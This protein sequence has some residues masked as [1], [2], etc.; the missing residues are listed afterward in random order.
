MSDIFDIPLVLVDDGKYYELEFNT[1]ALAQPS[2]FPCLAFL[3][4]GKRIYK[5]NIYDYRG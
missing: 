4:K 2:D 5:K 1:Y 3:K